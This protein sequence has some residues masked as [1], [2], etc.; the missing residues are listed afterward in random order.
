MKENQELSNLVKN[1]RKCKVVSGC[2]TAGEF[3]IDIKKI[4]SE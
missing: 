4:K 3:L 1:Y 2:V